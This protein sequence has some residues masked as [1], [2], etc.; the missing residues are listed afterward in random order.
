VPFTVRYTGSRASPPIM[1]YSVELAR[2]SHDAQLWANYED[3][4]QAAHDAGQD[5]FSFETWLDM[6]PRAAV[7]PAPLDEPDQDVVF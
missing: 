2:T 7:A 6:A 5:W 1:S 3:D 4:L